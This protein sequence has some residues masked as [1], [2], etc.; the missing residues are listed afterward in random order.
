MM[1]KNLNNLKNRS[2]LIVG[3]VM[4]DTYHMGDVK[5]IS[6]EAP[7][8]VVHVK[9]TYSVLG[10]A[11]NVARNLLGLECRP[12]VIGLRGDD[13]NGLIMEDMFEQLH[14]RHTVLTSPYPTITKTRVVGN[15]Q[16]VVRLDFETPVSLLDEDTEQQLLKAIDRALPEAEL[17]VIS[18]YGKGV[19]NATLCQYIIRQA[20]AL[21]KAVIID[22]KGSD[23][24][25]YRQATVITPN[26]KELS[27]VAG[28]DVRNENEAVHPVADRILRAYQLD[29]LLV[30]RSEKG[31]SYV[32]PRTS[33][34]IPTEAREVYD[35]SGAGDTVVATLAAAMAAGFAV[36]DALFLANKAAG[37]VVGKIGTSP[38]LYK[39]LSDQLGATGIDGKIVRRDHLPELVQDLRNKGRRIVFTNGCFDILHRGHVTYLNKARQLGDVLILGLN[40]DESVHRLKGPTRPVNDEQSRAFVMAALEAVDY[41]VIFG[42]DTPH[43]LIRVVAPDVLVKGGDYK[44]ED[45][46]GRE[47]ARETVIIPFVD[48]FSTTQTIEKMKQ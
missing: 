2:I 46:V 23:W 25:K 47:F 22:P 19:C 39:E 36:E 7:V 35:V 45:I 24:D 38:I 15:N 34:D 48:G 12:V 37:V 29:S 31:M 1:N 3:D 6:P 21:G 18:D 5:R 26:L 14:I 43:D 42:E 13:H 9:R 30:T 10:G 4:L 16:Q 11:A 44:I 33:L 8:P 28:C 32:S 27:V 40:S 20:R 17:V 41:V